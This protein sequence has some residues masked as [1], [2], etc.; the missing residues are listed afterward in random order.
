VLKNKVHT[1]T[2]TVDFITEMDQP[3]RKK[4]ASL[5]LQ[6]ERVALSEAVL[7][8][9]LNLIVW[10]QVELGLVLERLALLIPAK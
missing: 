4:P 6:P 10:V 8:A 5:R 7:M 9:Q 1:V 2:T 3:A